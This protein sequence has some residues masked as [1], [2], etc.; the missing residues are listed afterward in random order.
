M[1]TIYKQGG[2]ER[3]QPQIVEATPL[4]SI[5]STAYACKIEYTFED[6]LHSAVII[7]FRN[8]GD[9]IPTNMEEVKSQTDL[10]ASD[11]EPHFS[12]EWANRKVQTPG[13]YRDTATEVSISEKIL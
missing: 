9:P 12:M 5:N 3:L 2:A 6:S 4:H 1:A 13:K 10:T 7:N 11:I 8:D